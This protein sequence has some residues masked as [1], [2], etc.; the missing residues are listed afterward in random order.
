MIMGLIGPVSVAGVQFIAAMLLWR[1]VSPAEFGLFSFAILL[2]QFSYGLSNALVGT[3]LS[4]APRDTGWQ[5]VLDNCLTVHAIFLCGA[6]LAVFAALWLAGANASLA[7][8]AL[9]AATSNMRWAARS[10]AIAC[11]R[12][13]VSAR[14]DCAFA[15]VALGLLCLGFVT[16]RISLS[17]ITYSLVAANGIAS[18]AYNRDFLHCQWRAI[19]NPRLRHYR[20]TI[21]PNQVRWSLSGVL[22]SEASSNAHGYLV[23]AL[24]GAAAF[25]PLAFASL[26]WRPLAIFL[27]AITQI[28]RPVYARLLGEK[29]HVGVKALLQRSY[30]ASGLIWLGNAACAAIA[31]HLFS[32]SIAGRGYHADMMQIALLCW[33]AIMGVRAMRNPIGTLL[34]ARGAFRPLAACSAI[35]AIVSVSVVAFLAKAAPHYSLFGILAGEAVLLAGLFLT[36]RRVPA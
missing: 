12:L 3:P 19:I 9:L 20:D 5:D 27:T 14:A 13:A 18:F 1:A 25:A 17:S 33:C 30:A 8:F 32:N 26:F 31:L 7:G 2:I 6:T 24:A 16:G 29:D 10:Y 4:V 34:Q 28:D 36:A 23:T 11:E 15:A 35:S 22:T 21:W